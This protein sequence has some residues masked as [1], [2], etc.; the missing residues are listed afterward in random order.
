MDVLRSVEF[1]P[2]FLNRID[3]TIIFHPLGMGEL[4]RIVDIQLK[5]LM[6]QVT[7]AGL[8][9]TVTDAAKRELAEEGF[10]PTYGA[11]PL[12]RVIQ[13]RITN[14]LANSLLGGKAIAGQTIE[15][16]HD[17]EGF[18]FTPVAKV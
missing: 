14:P 17:G 15:V 11:R 7:E 5:R 3:E 6:A 12:K 1:L 16:G 18:T 2:E 8:S 10:D 4:T 9:L 13:Q